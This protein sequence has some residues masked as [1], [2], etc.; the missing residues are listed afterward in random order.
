MNHPIFAKQPSDFTPLAADAVKQAVLIP[1]LAGGDPVFMPGANNAMPAAISHGHSFTELSV[2]IKCFLNDYSHDSHIRF[3][4]TPAFRLHS[5]RPD[6]KNQPGVVHGWQDM[7]RART[8]LA[9]TRGTAK[10]Q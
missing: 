6:L 1:F 4:E 2:S 8:Q 7:E 3:Y 9:P 5:T 10:R